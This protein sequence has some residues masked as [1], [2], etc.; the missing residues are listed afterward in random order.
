MP[1]IKKNSFS[2][3][4]RA[5]LILAIYPLLLFFNSK[6]SVI[7]PQ[8]EKSSIIRNE[9]INP[10]SKFP[11]L[12][13]YSSDNKSIQ[14]KSDISGCL[15]D[16]STSFAGRMAY[17]FHYL[18]PFD[19]P[20][21]LL[22]QYGI[23]FLP[24]GNFTGASLTDSN[25]I[26]LDE[27]RMLYASIYSYQIDSL[28]QLQYLSS[29]NP[30]LSPYLNQ[31]SIDPIVIEYF[32]YN[33]FLSNAVDSNLVSITCDQ[34]YD[35]AGRTKSP[36]QND[37][38]F[39]IAPA[40]Q[41][42]DINEGVNTFIVKTNF[43]Y[44]NTGK[45][46]SQLWVATDSLGNS[47]QSEPLN[48][49][50]SI[51]F[52]SIGFF[53]IG[54]KIEFNDGTILKAH[55]KVDIFNNPLYSDTVQNSSSQGNIARIGNPNN[56][57]SAR[58]DG[59]F[60][61]GLPWGEFFTDPKTHFKYSNPG[62][63]F[64]STIPF[65]GVKDTG[66]VTI[67]LSSKNT[68]GT[69]EKPLIIVDGFDP[70]NNL[71]FDYEVA[72]VLL[73]YRYG[74]LDQI[75]LNDD[76]D[77]LGDYDLIYL[78]YNNGTDYIERNALL[79][80]TLIKYINHTKTTWHGSKQQN[81][82]IGESMGGI[83]T[84]Y[85]LDYMEENNDTPDTRLF[86]SHDAPEFGANV[87]V[88]YQLMTEH[89]AEFYKINLNFTWKQG[90]SINYSDLIPEASIGLGLF[91]SEAAKELLVQ[92]YNLQYIGLNNIVAD[93]STYTN[94]QTEI[95]N[96][97]YPQKSKNISIA[98]GAC[99]GTALYPP[100][101]LLLNGANTSDN[102][103]NYLTYLTLSFFGE[104]IN[105]LVGPINNNIEE[106]PLSVFGF[107]PKLNTNFNVHAIPT[108]PSL[109]YQGQVYMNEWILGI[110][111]V[112]NYLTNVD[113]NST[114]SMLPLDNPQG[115]Y[116]NIQIF[117][118]S[119]INVPSQFQRFLNFSE[120][121]PEFS[122]VPTVS[123][124]GI[125]N[126]WTQLN[127]SFCNDIACYTPFNDWYDSSSVNSPHDTYA[128]SMANYIMDR[129]TSGIGCANLC[130]VTIT[131]P[132]GICTGNYTYSVPQYTDV[133]YSWTVSS[134]LQI[135]GSSTSSSVVI[136]KTTGASGN[137][138][139]TVTLSSPHCSSF[140][141]QGSETITITGTPITGSYVNSGNEHTLTTTN[142][143]AGGG[144]ETVV[145]I[146][147]EGNT[148]YSW[149]ETGNSS[150]WWTSG[151][152]NNILYFYLSSGEA[153][154]KITATTSCG[155]TYFNPNFYV[156]GDNFIISPNPSTGMVT[157][158]TTNSSPVPTSAPGNTNDSSIQNSSRTS[159]TNSK[160]NNQ[161][162]ISNRVEIYEIKV[163]NN[164]GK[165]IKSYEYNNGVPHLTID[166]SDLPSSTYFIEVKT[167]NSTS[168]KQEVI[169]KN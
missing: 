99:N 22:Q 38:L 34:I 133:T 23:D 39:A 101:T 126:P 87:P 129:Q 116:Y 100:G 50:F 94:F 139:L 70:Y 65:D 160:L 169:L 114:T 54:I 74:F 165:I 8:S 158:T 59:Y 53:D 107:N 76:L 66:K 24:V 61:Y 131:G 103:M 156:S 152:Y 56:R 58:Y 134:G 47:W 88:G 135:V 124:L 90:L 127:S 104:T 37:T 86:I 80:E 84:R 148:E 57:G 166:L 67:E 72:N 3:R 96:M 155:D 13:G 110:I 122:F 140:P 79:L 91:T 95:N 32:N 143:V 151:T 45:T 43:L 19:V 132:N 75:S 81:V 41:F 60:F 49:P 20:T 168:T 17:V 113:V 164:I 35:V 82:I 145:T 136:Q 125:S 83:V 7:I 30:S 5:I 64:Y 33:S 48:S 147:P 97:G 150:D 92:R 159:S 123:A 44:T 2:I 144:T 21:G 73:Y 162:V 112:K 106:F 28:P 167:N 120:T 98:D 142:Q 146:N 109:I 15:G 118:G 138:T 4:Q 154:F 29:I 153:T 26:N 69:I 117:F 102:G 36:Y 11:T 157:I 1:K 130:S 51:S 78:Q 161:V 9:I 18:N 68:S 46:I 141:I 31:D 121:N 14:T 52:D 16:T 163:L 55:S 77:T 105:A 128:Q 10:R 119:Q 63:P 12:T 137:Q 111:Y 27:W 93:N 85:A 6:M 25:F 115:G 89:L 108:S 71:D 149:T 62:I 40:R 42:M